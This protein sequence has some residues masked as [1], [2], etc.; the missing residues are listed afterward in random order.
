MDKETVVD[1]RAALRG[2]M[3]TCVVELPSGAS[4]GSPT[5]VTFYVRPP[6]D[7]L[8]ESL[9]QLR[10]E[11]QDEAGM[12]DEEFEKML[13]LYVDDKT[14]SKVSYKEAALITRLVNGQ[15]HR[16]VLHMVVDERGAPVFHSL[17]EVAQVGSQALDAVLKVIAEQ[18]L[19]TA[20]LPNS[21]PS[22]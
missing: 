20:S 1:V 22:A 2:M 21:P 5:K 14:R 9:M 13:R 11:L 15:Q 10:I 18:V 17:D 19:Q 16:R 8:D 6:S 12:S 7:A 3:R 4:T